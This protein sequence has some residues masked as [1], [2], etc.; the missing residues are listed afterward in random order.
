MELIERRGD[1]MT[2]GYSAYGGQTRSAY[3]ISPPGGEIPNW[4]G[5]VTQP[6]LPLRPQPQ[7]TP[8]TDS[9]RLLSRIGR[10]YLSRLCSLL[11]WHRNGRLVYPASKAG[12]YA[13]RL[14]LAMCPR[15]AVSEL[16]GVSMGLE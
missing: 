9:R 7:L 1:D 4:L 2:T 10:R 12:L 8:S 11:N 3:D 16:V 5:A 15:K 6:N 13:M 14:P